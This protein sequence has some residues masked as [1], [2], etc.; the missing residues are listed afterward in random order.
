MRIR[1]HRLH[2][3]YGLEGSQ[4]VIA[5]AVGGHLDG[6][7][8]P[9]RLF[10]GQLHQGALEPHRAFGEDGD[11]IAHLLHLVQQVTGDEHRYT[12]VVG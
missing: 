12:L 5:G 7:P 9:R 1:L 3:G 6:S 10:R 2:A 11:A 8:Q 4:D